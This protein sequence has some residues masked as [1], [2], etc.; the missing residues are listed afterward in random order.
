MSKIEITNEDNM[1]LMARYE[2]NHFDLS[3][4]RP[5]LWDRNGWYFR[6]LANIP[7]PTKRF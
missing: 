7:N 3:Y 6:K 5:S 4:C 2:D 1:K